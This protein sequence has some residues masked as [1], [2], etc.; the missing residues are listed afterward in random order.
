MPVAPLVQFK[1]FVM[2]VLY[3]SVPLTALTY[4]FSRRRRRIIEVERVSVAAERRPRVS[5]GL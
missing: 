4:Y 3:I 5:A 2:A 1:L